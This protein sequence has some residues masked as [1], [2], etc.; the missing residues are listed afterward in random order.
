MI[1][2]RRVC[3]ALAMMGLLVSPAMGELIVYSPGS[4][5]VPAPPEILAVPGQTVSV[6]LYMWGTEPAISCDVQIQFD[7][8][9][10]QISNLDTDVGPGTLTQN[11]NWSV[12]GFAPDAAKPWIVRVGSFGDEALVEP[13]GDVINVLFSVLPS[14]PLGQTPITLTDYDQTGITYLSG[15]INI[16][17]EPSSLAL[18]ASLLTIGACV[19]RLHKGLRVS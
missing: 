7:P 16:V 6:P 2:Q 3:L 5:F 11:A 9:V 10:L 4:S 12:Y 13:S 8:V 15:F 1:M 18:L 19:S 14:A 17:P